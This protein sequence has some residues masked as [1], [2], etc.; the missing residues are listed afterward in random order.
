MSRYKLT[1]NIT[2]DCNLNGFNQK[3]LKSLSSVLNYLDIL[4]ELGK[5]D[6]QPLNLEDYYYN[7]IIES[8]RDGI[9]CLDD[10]ER[11]NLKLKLDEIEDGMFD[12]ELIN[13]GSMSLNLIFGKVFSPENNYEKRFGGA[14]GFV[15]RES[16]NLLDEYD[17]VAEDIYLNFPYIAIKDKEVFLENKSEINCID[18][19]R[20][21]GE[22]NKTYKPISVFY[23][24]KQSKL[25]PAQPKVALFTNIYYKRY[26][27]ISERLGSKFIENFYNTEN[28]KREVLNRILLFWLRG[29]DL[30]HFFGADNLGDN[31]RESKRVYYILHELKSDIVS[32]YILKT[33]YKKLFNKADIKSI[34]MVFLSEVFRYMRRGSFIKYADG[35]SA[36]L[37]YKY[38]LDSGSIKLE[39]GKIHFVNVEMLSND[40]DMLCEELIGIF[41]K[42]DAER[43]LRFSNRWG[44]LEELNDKI[45]PTELDFLNDYSIP[46]NLNIENP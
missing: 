2:F 1:S 21:G 34:Y 27:V 26:E 36:Y 23:T 9:Q 38:F 15:N 25:S 41:E 35:G 10:D 39:R 45:L 29:H 17:K 14:L 13:Y 7:K 24:G 3:T 37:A 6:N 33:S 20:F 18:V 31:M 42:G 16:D 19:I 40:I 22:L 32:L 43:A 28:T 4:N 44:N 12:F 30:G 11:L 5:Q 46:F 8:L